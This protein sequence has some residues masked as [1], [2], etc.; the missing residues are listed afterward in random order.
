MSGGL[1]ASGALLVTLAQPVRAQTAAAEAPRLTLAMDTRA[2]IESDV[3]GT[4]EDGTPRD[5]RHRGRIRVRLEARARV[6][7]SLFV[8]ARVRTGSPLSQQSP[9]LTVFDF[10]GGPRD[11]PR[12]VADRFVVQ[13]AGR[14]FEAW[15]GRNEFPFWS[16]NELF[17]D[18]DVTLPGGFFAYGAPAGRRL[19]QA[20]A[21]WFALPDG[22]V[23]FRGRMVAG[24][25]MAGGSIARGSSLQA[26]AGLFDL[27][28]AA[29]PK[30]LLRK[31]P[32]DY[33]VGVASVQLTQAAGHRWIGT[34]RIGADLL[35]NFRSYT[36]GIDEV[37]NADR[38]ARTGVALTTTVPG[39]V[40]AGTAGA[41]EVG[42][43]YA[44][45]EK[46][47]VHASFAQDDWVRWGSA[48]Q[49]DASNLRGHEVSGRYWLSR[50]VDVHA[51]GF[52]AR[53][54]STGQRGTRVRLDL[55]WR[56][57]VAP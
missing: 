57:T 28:G 26:A 31:S 44:Y 47:A 41:W 24:Q 8:T 3:H 23:E 15:A 50:G 18:R 6:G 19:V 2:R 51:R 55:N 25:V 13:H 33:R 37:P 5:D 4:R 22:A 49:T 52:F 20:R 43:T 39:R 11:D 38:R 40:G 56:L 16:Q 30:H 9:H 12:A 48:T 36:G 10:T 35:R 21:G 14:R 45:L 27:H 17:W 42:H 53:S 29:A 32:R 1:L 46:L 7:R 54:V 34:V